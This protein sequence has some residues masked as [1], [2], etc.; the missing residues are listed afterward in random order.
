VILCAVHASN[1]RRG[2]SFGTQRSRIAGRTMKM[3]EIVL[4]AIAK[5]IT[6]D[7]AADI[8]GIS[9]SSMDRLRRLYKRR[10]YDGFWVRA[11]RQG[12]LPT[13]PFAT[14]EQ[15]LLLYQEKYLRLDTAF[16]LPEAQQRAWAFISGTPW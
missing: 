2:A 14:V 13:V 10:G 5:K 8:L 1:A 4:R 6:W 16:P 9:Y 7:Q 15:I 11:R 3:R 12:H